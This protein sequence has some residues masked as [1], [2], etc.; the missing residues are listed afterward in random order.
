M[1]VF[2]KIKMKKNLGFTLVEV[3]IVLVILSTG[4]ITAVEVIR[5]GLNFMGKTRKKVIAINLAREWMEG[6]YNIRDTNFKRWAGVRDKCWLKANPLEDDDWNCTNDPWI[7]SWYRVITQSNT[8]N[9]YRLLTW[10]VSSALSLKDGIDPSDM[11]F[12]LC[13]TYRWWEACLNEADN[14]TK[15]G[16]FFREV[17]VKWL[18]DKRNNV[19]LS[20]N[21]WDISGCWDSTPKELIFCVNVGYKGTLW[22]KE[23]ICGSMTNFK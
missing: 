21:N 23:Q 9:R 6:M 8:S 12:A 3:I 2:C 4:I 15:E 18:L 7:Q 5:Y 17:E 22:G 10:K 11:H 1:Y 20:C 13:L 14:F 16:R 19:Y